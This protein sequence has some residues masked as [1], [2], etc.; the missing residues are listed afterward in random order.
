MKT[1]DRGPSARRVKLNRDARSGTHRQSGFVRGCLLTF[2]G[3][4]LVL[5]IALAATAYWFYRSVFHGDESR[6]ERLV[7]AGRVIQDNGSRWLNDRLV[8]LY[9][10]E[11]ETARERTRL[12]ALEP[13]L[14]TASDGVFVITVANPYGISTED[15]GFCESKSFGSKTAS[16]W[17]GDLRESSTGKTFTVASKKL[18]YSLRILP[19][20]PEALPAEL[21]EA[22]GTSLIDG[23]IVL[24]KSSVSPP[25]FLASFL[26]FLFGDR[27]ASSQ[28]KPA[29]SNLVENVRYNPLPDIVELPGEE[30]TL[31]NCGGSQAIRQSLT[32]SKTFVHEYLLETSANFEMPVQ[33]VALAQ[34]QLGSKGAYRHKQISTKTIRY[35]VGAEAGTSVSYKIRWMEVWKTGVATIHGRDG[36]SVALPLRAREDVRHAI[37]S[38]RQACGI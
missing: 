21:L 2:L 17:M 38:H 23:N 6:P 15:L 19:G 25:G 20:D 36:K 26:G 35:E 33:Q 37:E 31:N 9:V 5:G 29:S 11:A 1:Q 27:F 13:A 16:C 7:I 24:T 28:S 30:S 22:G 34:L 10:Q 8:L 32:E 14:A 3:I 12:R 4:V 18:S